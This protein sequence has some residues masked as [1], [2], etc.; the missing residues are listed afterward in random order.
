[1]P[2]NYVKVNDVVT[3]NQLATVGMKSI[4]KEHSYFHEPA[5]SRDFIRFHE[6]SR[7]FTRYFFLVFLELFELFELISDSL[8]TI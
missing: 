5:I 2:K 3:E 1:M 8:T 7:G 4:M 6:I